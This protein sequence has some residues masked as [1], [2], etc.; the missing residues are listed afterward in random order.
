MGGGGG[1]PS[2][3]DCRAHRLRQDAGRIP[4]RHRR[5]GA[6]QPPGSAPR[7]DPGALRLAAQGARERR[8]QEPGGTPRRH[9]PRA[10][11]GRRAGVGDP[12]DGAHRRHPERGAQRHAP[13]A[14]AH[15]GDHAGVALHPA[16]ERG[17]TRHAGE[18]RHRDRRRDPRRRRQQAG[19]APRALA[20]APGRA[21]R[22]PRHP[23]RTVRDP[24]PHRDH[25]PLPHRL[26]GRQAGHLHHRRHRPHQRTRPRAGA[27][28]IAARGGDVRRG[29]GRGLPAAPHPH[30]GAPH[31]ARVRQHP[32]HGGAGR[33]GAH[34]VARGGARHLAPRQPLAR[35][36]ARGRA[37]SQGRRSQGPGG[38]RLAGARDR[39]RGRRSG[40]PARLHPLHLDLSC[41]V[42][43]VPATR[44]TAPRR[45]GCFRSRGTSWSSAPRFSTRCGA[46]SS[47]R[48]TCRCIRSTSSRSRSSPWSRPRT[49]AR[50]RCSRRCTAPGRTG[51]S[52]ASDGGSFWRCSPADSRPGGAG[53]P[54]TCTATSSTA[55][56][57]PGAA[58]AS[59]R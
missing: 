47:I 21:R 4:H 34:R 51:I 1:G 31:H 49:G 57:A 16:H 17:R 27:A 39:H 59:P 37:A 3:P 7:R 38:H 30:R 14:P 5:P 55:S 53:A 28:R 24:A 33:A 32:P 29:L 20:R 9:R 18:R 50:T 11:R 54:R 40:L 13:A 45:G 25:R 56:C 58:P 8:A 23:H 19:R 52:T 42:P 41:N 22:A 43:G 15:P 10:G 46:A 48:C 26:R 6:R 35:A 12:G 36:P 44:C 2:H